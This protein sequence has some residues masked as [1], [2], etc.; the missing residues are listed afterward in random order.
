MLVRNPSLGGKRR[1]EFGD[2][3]QAA[4]AGKPLRT[5]DEAPTPR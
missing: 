4:A 1:F 5:H 2:A 3:L